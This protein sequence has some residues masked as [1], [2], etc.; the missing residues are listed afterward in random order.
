MPDWK[1]IESAARQYGTKHKADVLWFNGVILR[2]VDHKFIDLCHNRRHRPTALVVLTTPGGDAHA[3]YRMGRALQ[4]A[5]KTVRIFVPGW[6]KSAGTLLAIAANELIIG[7]FGE[8]GPIDVQSPKSDELWESSSGLTEESAIQT[9][10]NAAWKMFE[11]FVAGIKDMSK[12][13]ITFKTA[14]DAASPLVGGVLSPIFAQIDPLKIGENARAMQIASDY[15]LRLAFNSRNL[16]SKE[17]MENLVSGYSSHGFVIDREEAM[18]LFNKVS[19][20]DREIDN[21]C[22][23][24]GEIAYFPLE[25]IP[26]Q[27]R[28]LNPELTSR[29]KPR[30]A[31]KGKADE[32][33]PQRQATKVAG[34]NPSAGPQRNSSRAASAKE[35]DAKTNV[36][37]LRRPNGATQAETP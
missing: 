26:A 6:C 5:Y 23:L 18:E 1:K 29:G 11:S 4:R 13:Q 16:Q 24:L 20:P 33:R 9:L 10:E 19:K 21:L 30:K 36:R 15:G 8:L 31:K 2:G 28:F 32:A 7:D 25:D 27:M 37:E 34:R 14:A 35:T 12:G 17:S 22:E 3:A